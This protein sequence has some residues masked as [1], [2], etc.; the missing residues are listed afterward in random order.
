M[1][2]KNKKKVRKSSDQK[3]QMRFKKLMSS[4]NELE[5]EMRLMDSKLKKINKR[6][7]KKKTIVIKPILKSDEKYYAKKV[8]KEVAFNLE[9]NEFFW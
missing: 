2:T 3:V 5:R 8:K 4:G 6:T 7:K 9:E 1:G